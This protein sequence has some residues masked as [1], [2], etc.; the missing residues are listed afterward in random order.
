MLKASFRKYTLQ[1]K[2]PS[3]TSRGVLR[4]KASWFIML[5]DSDQPGVVGLGE[6]GLL[7]GL[8][9]DDLPGYSNMVGDVCSKI[10]EGRISPDELREWPSIRFGLEMALADLARGGRRSFYDT[11]FSEGKAPIPINGLVWM[12]EASFMQQQIREKLAAGF[13]CIKLKIGAIDFAS[14][15][16]L[17]H[18]IRKEFD[19]STTEIRVD[20]NGAFTPQDALEKLKRLSEFELHSIEQ[21]IKAG[22]WDEMAQLCIDTPLPI[23]LDEELIGVTDPFEQSRLMNTIQPQYII[24]KPSLVGGFAGS[25]EWIDLANQRNVPWWITSALESNVGLNAIAQFTAHTQNLMPQG[26]GTGGLYTNNFEAPLEVAHGELH[27]RPETNWD[28]SL[29]GL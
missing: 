19:A 22:Q 11:P 15:L 6:C 25:Q 14:E 8:S 27:F 24:L 2:R 5:E 9:Y 7:V 18:G 23:A 4:E 21:P 13:S 12:G 26:L 3:G 28:L 29:L 1:F 17:L 20:A 10:G 16:A